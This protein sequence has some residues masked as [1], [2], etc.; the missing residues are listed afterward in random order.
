MPEARWRSRKGTR[1]TQRWRHRGRSPP[2]QAGLARRERHCVTQPHH[3]GTHSAWSVATVDMTI[4][5]TSELDPLREV[6]GFVHWTAPSG[7]IL[8]SPAFWD[9]GATWQ[10]RVSL[11]EPGQWHGRA[12]FTA[13][14][15]TIVGISP[16]T[17]EA[18]CVPYE[19][20]NPLRVHGFPRLASGAGHLWHQDGTP[21]HWIGDTAWNGPMVA[22]PEDWDEFA[23][24]RAAQGFTV[25]QFVATQW[26]AL[27]DGG[28]D[29]PAFT[30]DEN[31][32]LQA[33]NH[34]FLR[35][36]DA[37]LDALT[38]H[39]LVGAPVLLWAHET[40]EVDPGDIPQDDRPVTQDMSMD[41]VALPEV[42][43]HNPGIYLP[44]DDAALLARHLVARWHAHPVAFILMGDGNYTGEK[45]DRWRRIG[46]ATFGEAP[47]G[48]R[49]PVV[50][51]PGGLQWVGA[52]FADEPWVD[53]IGYQSGHG[54]G[55]GSWR[56]LQDGSWLANTTLNA[57][58]AIIN[59]EACYEDHNRMSVMIG[60]P[61]GWTGRFSDRD[62][63]RALYG[64]SLVTACGGVTYG[65]HG[66]WSWEP[67]GKRPKGH[68]QTGE[69]KSWREAMSFAGAS[70]V[71]Y[72]RDHLAAVAWWRLRPAPWVLKWHPGGNGQFTR[73][74]SVARDVDTG[75]TVAYFAGAYAAEIDL[76]LLTVEDGA[77]VG[78]WRN[79]RDGTVSDAFPIDNDWI[80]PPDGWAEREGPPPGQSYPDD[81]L[82][83]IRPV[84]FG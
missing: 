37:R 78:E 69:S 38:V 64:S 9:G 15:G 75:T 39:G 31:G 27:P 35:R 46:R 50:V 56:W 4:G 80:V 6:N 13:S 44:E 73:W 42:I 28:P 47:T 20:D 40:K 84:R 19:G 58:Q 82:L 49:A 54:G 66:V 57:H 61:P 17:F 22:A 83:V 34:E 76:D 63:R 14:R 2:E 3:L 10:A 18:E 8:T 77:V 30:C 5:G 24:T 52:E 55:I 81:W 43:E 70:Q 33:L 16:D 48:D 45:A 29:G 36:L 25:I 23:R 32:S 65:A 53:V 71:R 51:H 7:R 79:P 72:F 41:D 62:V 74:V 59:L 12:S 11:D 60:V 67:G 1:Y 21:F 68:F 26:R